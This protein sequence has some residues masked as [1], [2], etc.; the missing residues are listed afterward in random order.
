VTASTTPAVRRVAALALVVGA[1][2]VA[3]TAGPV[4]SLDRFGTL[5]VPFVV[6]AVAFALSEVFLIHLEHRR[7]AVSL[8]LSTIPLIVGLYAVDPVALVLAR[9][10]G[11]GLALV[12]HRRQAPL[13]VLVNLGHMA[14]E[15]IVAILVFRAL[16][17]PTL[18]LGSW[19]AA[20]A[21]AVAGDVVQTAVLVAA[22]S[23]YQ[24]SWEGAIGESMVLGSLA[25]LVDT[26]VALVIVSVL[27]V[28]PAAVV[29]LG[30]ASVVLVW[31]YRAHNALRQQHRQLGELYDFTRVMG[32]AVLAERTVDVLLHQATEL[33]HA[34]AASVY[35]TLEDGTRCIAATADG[36][37]TTTTVG[38]RSPGATVQA[39]ARG[40]DVPLL[41]TVETAP[42]VAALGHR[43]LLVAELRNG[44]TAVGT[45]V[46]ADRR[47]E[48]R[49]FDD[50]D[51]RLFAMLANH[52]GMA[53][54]NSQLLDRLRV[55]AA[56][57]EYQS[58]HDALTGLPNRTLFAR[59]LDERLDDEEAVG[60]LLLDLDGFKDI[61]DTLGHQHGDLLL[62]Q[63]ADRLRTVLRQSD[64]IARLGGDEFAVLV[65]DVCAP[66]AAV[67]VARGLVAALE[68]PF[69]VAD[70]SIEIGA[71]I[72]VALAP[73]HG[74][75]AATLLQRADVAM[76]V[77]KGNQS[78]VEVYDGEH[79]A[80]TPERLALVGELRQ[81][82]AERSLEVHYQPQVDL[83]TG[84]VLGAE[85]LVRWQHPTR[86]FL[87]PDEF[88]PVAERTGL[89]GPLT[90]L[91]LETALAECARWR[92]T[93]GPERISV[94]LSARSLMHPS[95]PDD[96]RRLLA[97]ADLPASALC[98]EL[99]E[100]SILLEP[101]RTVPVLQRLTEIGV[102]V[103]IDDF[104]TGHSSLA[105]L[106]EL[107]VGEIKIDK[108]FVLTMAS[109]RSDEAIV[110]SI[111]GLAANLNLP[112]VA[113]GVETQ[114]L[115]QRLKM[116][117]CRIAQGYGFSRALPA[118]AFDAWVHEWRVTKQTG[119]ARVEG[120]YSRRELQR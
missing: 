13:K 115:A 105:Y 68:Q 108:S 34:D 12:L 69:S 27:R 113:E 104:G 41:L 30:L 38:E 42:A 70:V 78:D 25:R 49:R 47:G 21:A 33:L 89:I 44:A 111:I 67:G 79:D 93:G 91:V 20:V 119:P 35:V 114:A 1:S 82:I 6:F 48:V 83:V 14:M 57:S 76:Y 110:C 96:V 98:L 87:P 55:T 11:S 4:A 107:P 43:E 100:T 81:A 109:D 3:L 102:T 65:P 31:S 118:P 120:A 28:E 39:L 19:P 50:E 56:E 32:D 72:G 51:L 73:V 7:E 61:N 9:V 75:D 58:L 103:A 84:A 62:H 90:E 59:R 5:S 26:A 29:L 40:T 101:R 64:T 8:S 24:R 97:V 10:V 80:H 117:G 17:P 36:E 99:T 92:R 71:S 88:V 77:A 22:I 112:V 66:E 37:V 53:L 60:V 2:A 46:V 95:L 15:A 52:A 45:L 18:G 16:A 94:N 23:L 63:V 85:A 116:A 74:K 54:A 106:K 86:G